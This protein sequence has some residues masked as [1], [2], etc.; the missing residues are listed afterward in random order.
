MTSEHRA[1][2]LVAIDEVVRALAPPF[3]GEP[4]FARIVDSVVRHTAA[5]GAVAWLAD[6]RGGSLVPAARAGDVG[7][8]DVTPGARLAERVRELGES[9]YVADARVHAATRDDWPAGTA[10][11]AVPVTGRARTGRG[12]DRAQPLAAPNGCT[13]TSSCSNGS[14]GSPPSP[15]PPPASPRRRAES[16]GEPAR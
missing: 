13:A 3:E 9:V 15:S 16:S 7:G 8:R 6:A 5:D 12:A 2:H 1:R 11:C 10:L 4:P 14:R